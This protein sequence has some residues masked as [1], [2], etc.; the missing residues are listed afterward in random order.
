ME[1]HEHEDLLLPVFCNFEYNV[2]A[3]FDLRNHKCL[4]FSEQPIQILAIETSSKI[5]H[6]YSIRVEHRDNMKINLLSQFT[7]SPVLTFNE[8]LHESLEDVA[9]IGFAWVLSSNNE[10]SLL[11][12]IDWCGII[13]LLSFG[14][15]F[16][17]WDLE[18]T[19]GNIRCIYFELQVF[20]LL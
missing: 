20:C 5:S 3:K 4:V 1:I 12:N 16:N 14:V 11:F 2:L 13:F 17:I 19:E 7:N 8:L 18:S 9:A 10:D 6:H 15:Y